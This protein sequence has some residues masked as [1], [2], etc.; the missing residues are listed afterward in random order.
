MVTE[1]KTNLRK[2]R[3]SKG[4]TI[5]DV[6]NGIQIPKGTLYDIEIGRRGIKVEKA[7]K[8]ADFLGVPIESLFNPTYYYACNDT[9]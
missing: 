6:S 8:L 3:E 2:C 5:A 9:G 1:S 7:K 4:F